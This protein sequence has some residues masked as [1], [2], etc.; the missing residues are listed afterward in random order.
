[1]TNSTI[2]IVQ[3]NIKKFRE[4]KGLTQDKLS[5]ATVISADYISEIERGKKNPSLKR[6]ILIAEALEVDIRELFTPQD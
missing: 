1:M 3:K 5:E 2:L 6:L 4:I